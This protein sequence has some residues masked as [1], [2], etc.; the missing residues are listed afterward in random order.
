MP[1]PAPPLL[2]PIALP[3]ARAL[4][5]AGRALGELPDYGSA[6]WAGLADTDPRKVAACVLA[7]E[8]HRYEVATLAERTRVEL[9]AAVAEERRAFAEEADRLMAEVEAEQVWDRIDA[10]AQL[11]AL[12]E[13]AP[14]PYRE[15]RSRA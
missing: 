11:A 14:N 10:E 15:C 13:A 1:R 9:A 12:A 4:I 3:W 2:L 6:E 7:A 5:D 8:V